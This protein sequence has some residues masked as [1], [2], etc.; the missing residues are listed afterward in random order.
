[1]NVWQW[2]AAV[3]RDRNVIQKD[4]L[5]ASMYD[6]WPVHKHSAGTVPLLPIVTYNANGNDGE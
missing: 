5:W 3:Y 2:D 4:M 6:N 1:V